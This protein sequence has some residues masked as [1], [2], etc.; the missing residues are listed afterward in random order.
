MRDAVWDVE[1]LGTLRATRED[2]VITHFRTHKTGALFGYLAFQERPRLHRREELIEILWPEVDIDS[3]RNR[4]RI[5]LN[6]LRSEFASPEEMP[7][8]CADRNMVQLHPEAFHTDKAEFELLTQRALRAESDEECI[9]C[10]EKAV[11]LY[12]GEL[13]PGY[14]E[15]WIPGE[16]QRLA[17]AYLLALR[18]LTKLHLTRIAM[19]LR[20]NSRV[21]PF[22]PTLTGK[23][24]IE[25]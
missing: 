18:R 21:V 24:R 7:L 13:L 1:L 4:L 17:D 9:T 5:A 11:A 25:R 22:S 10:L 6:A 12:R 14:D 20:W 3:G 15:E 8:V 2:H 23:S 16:R 19:R